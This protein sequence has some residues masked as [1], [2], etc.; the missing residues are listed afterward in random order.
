MKKIATVGMIALMVF[1]FSMGISLG[2]MSRIQK[3]FH[4]FSAKK[5]YFAVGETCIN[6]S[7][8]RANL[9]HAIM[10]RLLHCLKDLNLSDETKNQLKS[11]LSDYREAQEVQNQAMLEAAE[12]Y[13]NLLTAVILDEAAIEEAESRIE[14]LNSEDMALRLDLL[15]S[16]R[17]LL[18]EEEIAQLSGCFDKEA[19]AEEQGNRM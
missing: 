10:K 8:F 7:Q 9:R 17:N 15:K 1:T 4:F 2:D 19:P 5:N 12:T 6:G 3:G 11:L 14:S 13:W 18:S 16:I